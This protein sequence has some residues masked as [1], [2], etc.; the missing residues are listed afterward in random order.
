MSGDC[1]W[2]V[3]ALTCGPTASCDA[4]NR[5]LKA[6]Q[7]RGLIPEETILLVIDD[8]VQGIGSGGATLNALLVITEHLAS[9]AGYT[10]VNS[11]VLDE[12]RILI[13]HMGGRYMYSAIGGAFITAPVTD[14]TSLPSDTGIMTILDHLIDVMSSKVA[15][16]S[17][18]GVWVCSTDMVLSIP[19][20]FKIEWQENIDTCDV[21]ALSVHGDVVSAQEHGI[22]V[23]DE[24]GFVQDILYRSSG[25][26]LGRHAHQ[27][28]SVNMVIGVVYFNKKA[29]EKLLSFHTVSPLNNCT[30]V[31]IDSGAKAI[32]VSL[33]FDLL[34]AMCGTDSSALPSKMPAARQQVDYKWSLLHQILRD[35]RVKA[36]TIE[37]GQFYYLFNDKKAFYSAI[38]S[39]VGRDLQG[40]LNIVNSTGGV[41]SHPS[42]G[43]MA[44]CRVNKHL[45][46]ADDVLI[47]GLDCSIYQPGEVVSIDK[48][49][50]YQHLRVKLS[51]D[52]QPIIVPVIFGLYDS[53]KA[54]GAD[55]TFC[56]AS[57]SEFYS[58]VGYTDRD[59]WTADCDARERTLD[60]A[61]LF[62]VMALGKDST[63][64]DSLVWMQ[65]GVKATSA[66]VSRWKRSWKLSLRE[67]IGY[68]DLVEE[69]SW[70]R[71]LFAELA[72]AKVKDTIENGKEF[73]LLTL[74]K[75]IGMEQ[76]EHYN[77][78]LDTLDNV[79]METTSPGVAARALANVADVLGCMAASK[80]GLRSGPSANAAWNHAYELLECGDFKEGVT[81]LAAVRTRWLSRGELVIRAARHYE[82]A[83]RILIRRAV[84]SASKFIHLTPTDDMTPFDR[85]VHAASPARAD[86]A[87]GWS[88]TPPISYEHG[89]AVTNAAILVDDMKPIG[90][91]MRRIRENKIVLVLN[92]TSDS[93]PITIKHLD[94]LRDY[95]QPQVP[96]ALLKA[97][98][99]CAKVVDLDSEQSLDQQLSSRYGGGFELRTWSK[100]PQGSGLGTSSILAGALMA[101]IWKV[102]GQG[103]TGSALIHA[104][105]RVEQML[106]TGGG[107]QDQVGGLLPGIKIG[108]SKAALP[109]YVDTRNIDLS[110]QLLLDFNDRFLL[111]YTGK[112]R[113]ARNLLQ[114]VVRN[115]YARDPMIVQTQDELVKIAYDCEKAF[116]SA[117]LVRVGQL[118]TRY[119]ELKKQMA[120]GCEPVFVSH[121]IGVLT[122]YALACCM[123]GAG[124]GGFLYVLT[125]EPNQRLLVED[126]LAKLKLSEDYSV[127][128]ASV[129]TEGFTISV[130]SD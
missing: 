41:V 40:E 61:Q 126:L 46:L 47:S 17:P 30:Y 79:A 91:D 94:G 33:F 9:L 102:T 60:R 85:W 68:L 35:L 21:V 3:I 34:Y 129:C 28:G 77:A 74:Y 120:T 43:Y 62:P 71:Q 50:V 48:G 118:W 19:E 100:L 99:I 105:L 115:W 58:K 88:D 121:M 98:L 7:S 117:D 66:Q 55:S 72:Q 37:D 44:N 49:I 114:N 23:T 2:N 52:Q 80:G 15:A 4:L 128:K 63:Y 12:E 93:S 124:G 78:I 59:L 69:F 109:L 8:P 125:K 6:R 96:G 119:W 127:H 25:E 103:Y 31:G 70:R 81:Q 122:P 11:D 45:R 24:K 104:V 57:W 123:A 5:E 16:G 20:T 113:L 64:I 54:V 51:E 27:D 13:L 87:G 101:V 130:E 67:I 95:C 29:T 38:A 112:T 56:N 65:P 116:L 22:Y 110:S 111:I 14:S 83:A 107:W 106:T 84:L 82:G 75:T 108:M 86:I 39:L 42:K 76:P 32:Q 73:S 1:K 90:C 89:G 18:P 92:S 53:F 26:I 36:V 97:A 10:V